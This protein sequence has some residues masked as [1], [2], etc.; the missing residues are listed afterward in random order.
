MLVGKLMNQGTRVF[1]P[2][3]DR[4][5]CLSTMRVCYSSSAPVFRMVSNFLIRAKFS[6]SF[7]KIYGI[8]ETFSFMVSNSL[9]ET[10]LL[11]RYTNKSKKIMKKFQGNF[12]VIVGNI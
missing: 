1:L 4:G 9:M 3:V 8:H 11:L 2:L 10:K 5:R 12:G 7:R 6:F